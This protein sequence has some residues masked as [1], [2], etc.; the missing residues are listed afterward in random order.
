MD[1]MILQLLPWILIF[2]IM[3][4]F[5]LRPQIKKQKEQKK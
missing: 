5:F 2:G 3:Y 1:G 4:L